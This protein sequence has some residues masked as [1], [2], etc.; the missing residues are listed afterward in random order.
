M[1]ALSKEA[2][3]SIASA[4][5]MALVLSRARAGAAVSLVGASPTLAEAL[6]ARGHSVRELPGP[7]WKRGKGPAPALVVLE[8][9]AVERVLETGL[10][11]LRRAAPG[12]ELMFGLRN[13]GSARAL[14]GALTGEAP[15]RA[16]L[17][18]QRVLRRLAEAGYRVAH[19][20]TVPCTSEGTALADDT[21]QALRA[22]L[23]QLSPSTQVEEGLYVA[24]PDGPVREPVAGLLSV[25]VTVGAGT[26]DAAL[27][28]ALF[29]LA[30]QEQQPLE[31]LL[32]APEGVDLSVA[33]AALERYGRLG[34]FQSRIVRAP[35][36]ALTAEAVR[37]ARGQYLAFL[38]ARCLVYPRH[39]VQLVQALQAGR[40]AWA[41]ARAFRT[42]WASGA[43][44]APYVRAK[45]PFPLGERLEVEHLVVHP[46]L[47]HAMVI[48]RGRIGPFPVVTEAG[49]GDLPARLGALFP[50]VFLGG[51]ASC[52]VRGPPEPPAVAAVPGIWL[53]RPLGAWVDAVAR[54]RDETL[55][56]REFRHRVVDALN[57]RIHGIPWVHTTLRALANRLKRDSGR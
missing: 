38:D 7:E 37:E 30:G 11:A 28:E 2:P 47:V 52:E 14:M 27:D 23:A 24:V 57:D 10:E 4:R 43:G 8:G 53:V 44:T 19:R 54:I 29:A 46:E 20:E 45:V 56:A 21:T 9:E 15:V 12:A 34:S 25:V 33:E 49:L 39:Y 40:E 1:N 51:I 13:A 36:S 35:S 17:S 55:Q 32:A 48:D 16:G 22:L 6:R 31:L 42:E 41:V 50:P 3:P 5:W 18:E 26:R